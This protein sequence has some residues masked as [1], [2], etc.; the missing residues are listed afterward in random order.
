MHENFGVFRREDQMQEQGRIIERLKER[1]RRVVVEDKGDVFNNDLTQALELGF[2]L[3]L[4]EC[5][6]VGST[7]NR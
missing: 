7:G 2:L 6:V 5:M 4:A 1:Y 3:D